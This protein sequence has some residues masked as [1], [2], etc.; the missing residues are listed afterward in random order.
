[1]KQVPTGMVNP[2][3]PVGSS[4][5]SAAPLSTSRVQWAERLER[6]A[7]HLA[8]LALYFVAA[9]FGLHLAFVNASAT[10]IWAPTGI[11]LAAVLAFGYRVWPTIFIAA[12][13]ANLATA[14]AIVPSLAIALGNTLEALAGA[15]LLER[16][17]RGRYAVRRAYGIL[18]LAILAGMVATAI[19]ATIGVL[20]IMA[21]GQAPW[22]DFKSIWFTWWVG[23]AV[24]ALLVAPALL[25]WSESTRLLW[26]ALPRSPTSSYRFWRTGQFRR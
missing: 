9:R 2:S 11:A 6:I 12:F 17:A 26:T 20:T 7:V 13:L 3:V 16:F 19:S 18:K 15:M 10:A 24:G 4:P 22:P 25:L 1:M 14:G 23:D 21:A 8:I 5:R